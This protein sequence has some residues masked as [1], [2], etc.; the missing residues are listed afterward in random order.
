MKRFNQNAERWSP[1]EQVL[2]SRLYLR[3]TE[4]WR[5]GAEGLCG[6]IGNA[7]GQKSVSGSITALFRRR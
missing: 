5:L 4:I 6:R 3:H 1:L 7:V 2:S